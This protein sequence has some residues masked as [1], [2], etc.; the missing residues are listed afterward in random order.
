MDEPEG[1]K[2]R[3]GLKNGWSTASEKI[4]KMERLMTAVNIL[5]RKIINRLSSFQ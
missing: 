4:N 3:Y 2:I 5:Q 1:K